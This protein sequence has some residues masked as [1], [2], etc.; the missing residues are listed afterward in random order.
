LELTKVT[1]LNR[2]AP[3]LE[4]GECYKTN[5]VNLYTRRDSIIMGCVWWLV[6]MGIREFNT[7]VA[8]VPI[9]EIITLCV[10]V[11]VVPLGRPSNVESTG[12]GIYTVVEMEM[13]C[14]WIK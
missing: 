1:G 3:Q 8:V 11:S 6:K 4:D 5:G 13:N 9:V 12:L 2:I 14:F 10:V 7:R